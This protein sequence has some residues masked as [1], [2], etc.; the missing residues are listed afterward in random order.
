[1]NSQNVESLKRP[2]IFKSY[3]KFWFSH[4]DE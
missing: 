2:E 4:K 3:E 1:V